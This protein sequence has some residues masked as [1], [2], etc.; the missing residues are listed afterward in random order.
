VRRSTFEHPAIHGVAIAV[1]PAAVG[2]I[3]LTYSFFLTP[4]HG[5]PLFAFGGV[6]LLGLAFGLALASNR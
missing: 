1:P 5:Q 2:V 6:F 3:A 4:A